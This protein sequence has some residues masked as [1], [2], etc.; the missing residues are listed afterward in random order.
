MRALRL[1]HRRDA[2]MRL[3]FAVAIVIVV[4]LLV[5]SGFSR[6]LTAAEATLLDAVERGDRAA[7]LRLL[8]VKGTNV[9]APGPDGTTPIMYAA[10]SATFQPPGSGGSQLE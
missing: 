6:T 2:F 10:A 9:N 4:V 1:L 5:L 8:A 3:E 7:A